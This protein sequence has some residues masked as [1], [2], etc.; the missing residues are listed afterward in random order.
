[1][2][3][4]EGDGRSEDERHPEAPPH[5]ALHGQG[6][7][8]VGHHRCVVVGRWR[9]VCIGAM[10]PVVGVPGHGATRVSCCFQRE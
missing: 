9:L 6:H 3:R 5:V 8:R 7:G 4:Q 10:G 1:M 2:T